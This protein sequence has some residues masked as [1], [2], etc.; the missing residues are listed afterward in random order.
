MSKYHLLLLFI[1]TFTACSKSV[2]VM[3]LAQVNWIHGAEDCANNTDP[4]IQIVRYNE[5][6]WIL[7]QSK[8]SNYEAPFMFLFFGKEK[9]LLMDTGAT[10]EEQEFPLY[11]TVMG[12][13]DQWN[14]ENNT[15]VELVVAHT[16]KHGDHYSA[17][18]QF[19]GKPNTKVLGLEVADLTAFFAIDNWP[20]D[21]STMNLGDRELTIIPIPG[22]QSS[23]IAVY[24]ASTKLLLTGDTF[25]PGRLY[26]NDWPAF[27]KSIDRLVRFTEKNEVSVILGNHIEMTSVFGKDYPMG[28]PY[29]PDEMILPL[30]TDDLKELAAANHSIG[31]SAKLE[32][33]DR[34]IIYPTN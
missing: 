11:Q 10:K 22:H 23:S 19:R 15:S 31:D 24:D 27:K 12:I 4:Q 5:D 30:T 33:H 8:C 34:F 16:H 1:L 9:A 6:T 26:V 32:I 13:M 28:T 17:D 2:D 29:Q 20:E 14:A 3:D 7:R 25:Y 21:E 18:G